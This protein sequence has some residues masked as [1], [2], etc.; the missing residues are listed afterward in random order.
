MIFPMSSRLKSVRTHKKSC[1]RWREYF[2]VPCHPER[3]KSAKISEVEGSACD[4]EN[5]HSFK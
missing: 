5:L 2:P 4:G 1:M 3:K